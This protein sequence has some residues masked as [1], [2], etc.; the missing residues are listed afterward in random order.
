M[1]K[2]KELYKK[3]RE[4]IMYLI[5]GGLTTVV[6]WVIYFPLTNILHIHYQIANVIAWVCAVVFAY[7]T[8]RAWVFESKNKNKIIEFAKFTS[9]RIFS[10]LAEMALLFVLIDLIKFNENISKIAGA[11]VVVVLNYILS[12]VFVFKEKKDGENGEK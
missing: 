12:K 2:L 9:G 5:F 4:Y 6:N 1:N 10:L 8:N 11:V 7:F 3:Y